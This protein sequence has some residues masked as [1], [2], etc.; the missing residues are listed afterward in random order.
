MDPR[1]TSSIDQAGAGLRSISPAVAQFY[2]ALRKEGM[3]RFDAA[4]VI[5]TWLNTNWLADQNKED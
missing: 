5:A 1:F 4:L 3:H 2:S